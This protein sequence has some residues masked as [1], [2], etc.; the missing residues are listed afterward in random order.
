MA[1]ANVAHANT[2]GTQATKQK[3]RMNARC[4]TQE[5][6]SLDILT[7]PSEEKLPNV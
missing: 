2:H 1:F 7:T 4:A 3:S 6:Q 5:T